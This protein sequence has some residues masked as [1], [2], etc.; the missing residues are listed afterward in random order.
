MYYHNHY[1][2]HIPLRKVNK[3]NNIKNI[4][5]FLWSSVKYC[6]VCIHTMTTWVCVQKVM[7][8]GIFNKKKKVSDFK[9]QKHKKNSKAI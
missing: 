5:I 9:K 3:Y 2:K 8:D 7:K 6:I 1:L 4:S